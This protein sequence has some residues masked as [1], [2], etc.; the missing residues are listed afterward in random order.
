MLRVLSVRGDVYYCYSI[1]L[2]HY[3]KILHP[4][5]FLELVMGVRMFNVKPVLLTIDRE[6][7]VLRVKTMMILLAYTNHCA[8]TNSC[9]T[10][11]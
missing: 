4:T 11:R 2:L 10:T 8:G 6:S 5:R 9:A 3:G 1:L 7:T